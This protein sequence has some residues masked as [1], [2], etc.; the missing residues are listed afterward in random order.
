[1]RYTL[2]EMVQRILESMESDEVST[3]GE[4]PESTSVANIIKECYFDLIG[5]VN[6]AE[7]EGLFK[8][9]ASGDN[10]RPALMYLPENVS[11]MVWL[12]YNI[13]DT[14]PDPEYQYVSY[15]DNEEFLYYNTGL[16]LSDPNVSSMEISHNGTTFQFQLRTDSDPHYYTILN[17]RLIIFD[18]YDSSKEVTLTEA[19]SLGWGSLV[20]DFLIEDTF[21]PDLDPRQFQLLLNEAKAQAFIE[22]KQST[23]DKAEKRARKNKILAKKQRDDNDPSWANQRHASFGRRAI[24][25]LTQD[26]I[27]AMRR[28][29]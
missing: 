5:E 6:P 20:P 17:D 23:N 9:S 12:K 15:R 27:R 14:F 26:M 28:G 4:T 13:S 16:D 18:S 8:L 11:K 10:T 7:T 24:A 22:L 25:S 2:L 1:M 29:K 21:I 19:R 3:V